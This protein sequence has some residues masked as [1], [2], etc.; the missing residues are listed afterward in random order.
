MFLQGHVVGGYALTVGIGG[1]VGGMR[2]V[3]GWY[4]G[5]MWVVC[6]VHVGCIVMYAS[7]C[8]FIGVT[9]ATGFIRQA[10][11]WADYQVMLH[12]CVNNYMQKQ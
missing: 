9:L 1:D 11:L 4:A 12:A 10:A 3:C 8:V 5:G 6:G 2:V 7:A